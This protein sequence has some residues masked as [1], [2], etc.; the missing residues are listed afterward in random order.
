MG[1]YQWSI[2]RKLEIFVIGTPLTEP[3]K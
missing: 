3:L 1:A 2:K